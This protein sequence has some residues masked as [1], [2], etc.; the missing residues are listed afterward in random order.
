LAQETTQSQQHLAFL[1][2]DNLKEQKNIKTNGQLA[3][4][5][6]KKLNSKNKNN[7][8]PIKHKENKLEEYH[9][10]LLHLN[11]VRR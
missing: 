7:R 6:A 9:A 2:S 3:S 8:Q 1:Y 10:T 11:L 5:I 4:L